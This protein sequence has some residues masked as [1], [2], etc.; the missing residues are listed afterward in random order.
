M[1]RQPT[2]IIRALAM[3]GLTVLLATGCQTYKGQNKKMSILWQQGQVQ[4]AATEFTAKMDAILDEDLAAIQRAQELDGGEE[5][6]VQDDVLSASNG[7]S[8]NGHSGHINRNKVLVT[9]FF[10]NYTC[11]PPG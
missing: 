1:N 9:C 6:P 10:H 7:S 4:A 8:S 11:V 5:K 3:S 2:N